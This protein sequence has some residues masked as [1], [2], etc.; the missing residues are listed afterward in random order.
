MSRREGGPVNRQLLGLLLLALLLAACSSSHHPAAAK[1]AALPPPTRPAV[2]APA[3]RAYAAAIDSVSVRVDLIG[4]ELRGCADPT[5]ACQADAAASGTVAFSLLRQ[6]RTDDTNRE[7]GT[8]APLPPRVSPL[9]FK[10]EKD[11]RSV[12]DAAHSVSAHSGKSSIAQLTKHV[13]S[14]AADVDA[15]EAGGMATNALAAAHV[16]VPPAPA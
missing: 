13:T 3:L 9:I 15:W 6:L 7:A 2:N 11:A 1:R 12:K 4:K 8:S 16:N 14:L 5:V 10:T